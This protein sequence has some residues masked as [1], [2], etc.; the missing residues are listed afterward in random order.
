MKLYTKSID[1]IL[2]KK[3]HLDYYYPIDDWLFSFEYA[4]EEL[5][6]NLMLKT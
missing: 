4:N 1:I 5:N 3:F 6:H 2:V